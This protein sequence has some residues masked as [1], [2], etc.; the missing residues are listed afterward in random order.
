MLEHLTREQILLPDGGSRRRQIADFFRNAIIAG[1]YRPGDHLPGMRAL[2]GQLGVGV[3]SVQWA[4]NQLANE[5]WIQRCRGSG[6]IVCEQRAELT[7]I[8]LFHFSYGVL[9][10][11][12]FG[13]L[14]IEAVEAECH[15]RKLHFR[16]YLER[17]ENRSAEPILAA[18]RRREFQAAIVLGLHD[19]IKKE[20]ERLPIPCAVL[21]ERF[22]DNRFEEAAVS[23]VAAN[24]GQRLALIYTFTRRSRQTQLRNFTRLAGACGL[25]FAPERDAFTPSAQIPPGDTELTQRFGYE[26]MLQLWRR[27]GPRPD[28]LV[29]YPDDLVP[30][31]LMALLELG[32]Q[33]PN[34]LR[35]FL[36][37]NAER[38]M[39]CPVDCVFVENR[40]VDFARALIE[41]CVAQVENRPRPSPS[42]SYHSYRHCF[43]P[44]PSKGESPC[45]DQ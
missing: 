12:P 8:G 36:H 18:Y 26:L 30:G 5:G 42:I 37:R 20:V 33:V 15:R 24:G 41:D 45:T 10:A 38:R 14:L 25:G 17:L 7:T 2:A 4:M 32:I 22:P 43:A 27:P 23:A 39:L 31:V 19:L 1:T 16:L 28:S 29:V 21:S 35:L 11:N 13:R 34:E 9:G 3:G 40:I 44:Q 6:T